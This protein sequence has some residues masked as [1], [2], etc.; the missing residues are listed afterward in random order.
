MDWTSIDAIARLPKA[1]LHAHLAGSVPASVVKELLQ[2]L[3]DQSSPA[4]DTPLDLSVLPILKPVPSL[5]E[6]LKAWRLLD[7]LPR[8]QVCLEQ[9]FRSVLASFKADG[10]VYT[11][12]RHSPLRVARLNDIPLE[13]ALVWGIEA[14]ENA[15]SKVPG[16]DARLIFGIDPARVDLAGIRGLLDAFKALG[17]PQ[18]MVG[19]D[20]AGDEA[21]YP[22][23]DDLTWAIRGTSDEL[24][25]GVTIHAG[26]TGPPE[27]I[28]HAIEECRATRIGHGLAAVRSRPLLDLIRQRKVCLEICLRSNV[29]T[30]SVSSLDEHPVLTLIEH[31][32]PFALCTDN[33]GVH[34]F[35][36]SQECHQFY[37]LTGRADILETMFNRQIAHAFVGA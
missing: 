25:L 6:Y 4:A 35:S 19:I 1:E 2:E 12:F 36:L 34:A 7:K 21:G 17:C 8:G 23:G 20:V 37:A 16:I 27:N 14:L 11:E 31:E 33:P 24:G 18:Q 22:I 10:V 26:E 32:I 15:K 30:G 28:R 9:I 3:A 29:L 13:T 5:T